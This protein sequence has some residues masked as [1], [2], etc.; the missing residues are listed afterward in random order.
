MKLWGVDSEDPAK[1]LGSTEE[2]I[3]RL[4]QRNQNDMERVH[5]AFPISTETLRHFLADRQL[6][7]FECNPS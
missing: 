2:E 4:V 1:R 7:N 6:R 5:A 3:M